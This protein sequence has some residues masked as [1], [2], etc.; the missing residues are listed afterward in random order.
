MIPNDK[1]I[2]F[3]SEEDQLVYEDVVNNRSG[4]IDTVS[5]K[6]YSP[7]LS[8]VEVFDF[9]SK[10]V[11]VK[12]FVDKIILYLQHNDRT[13]YD[14]LNEKEKTYIV[15]ILR[16]L[17]DYG[18]S[19]I[20]TK[21]REVDYVRNPVSPEEF[22][23][24]EAYIGEIG[25]N[26]YEAL[27]QEFYK[28]CN[29]EVFE[30]ILTGS[31]GWGKSYFA[32]LMMAYM[33]YKLSCLRNPHKFYGISENTPLVLMNLSVR[34]GNAKTVLFDE[35][36]ALC[37]QTHYFKEVFKRNKKINDSLVFPNKIVFMSGG[38]SEIS[39]IGQNLFSSCGDE[40]NF[41]AK[42]KN[43]RRSVDASG[44]YDQ[45]KQIYNSVI[46]RMKSRFMKQGKNAG[47]AIWISSK[48]YPGDFLE[49]RVD[50]VRKNKEKNVYII[51]KNQWEVKPQ[52]TFG[53][54]RFYV[55]VGDQTRNSRIIKTPE[56]FN[57]LRVQNQI[58]GRVVEV[59]LEYLTDFQNELEG[60][61]RDVAG[62]ATY[63]LKPYF[64]DR[65]K[66]YTCSNDAGRVK[67]LTQWYTNLQEAWPFIS[68]N[69]LQNVNVNGR[70]ARKLRH[71]PDASRFVSIDLSKT[72]DRTGFCMGC[73]AGH[74]V[75]ESVDQ[76]GKLIKIYRP[77]IFI[78][79]ILKIYPDSSGEV[80]YQRITEMVEFLRSMGYPIRQISFD[81]YQSTYHSQIFKT[82]GYQV[83]YLSVDR[84]PEAYEAL[85]SAVNGERIN[86]PS[87]QD[88]ELDGD[89]VKGVQTELIE[90]EK[91][92][93]G[94]APDHPQTGSKDT[95][96][97]LAAV[98]KQ[99][100][101]QYEP[102]SAFDSKIIVS[103]SAQ[104]ELMA[105][106]NQADP[107]SFVE[108]QM[109]MKFEDDFMDDPYLTLLDKMDRQD[110]AEF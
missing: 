102:P 79:M 106:V 89:L 96:D 32:G 99:I 29:D 33:L 95:A 25:K 11:T 100:E 64:S 110:L 18:Y 88:F 82:K 105:R 109:K 90:L 75:Y 6:V 107:F 10:N 87:M 81:Q 91:G 72:T 74:K 86:I 66:I 98:V 28:A 34:S 30:V 103:K 2:E 67:V 54:E 63:S 44:T 70:I 73:M 27:R 23:L 46:R 37:D 92:E 49:L 3:S 83:E 50:Q 20:L 94:D 62:I 78:D 108:E 57:K 69:I 8:R 65:S 26:L 84:T 35:L 38:S 56:E 17:A 80:N 104:E 76:N 21:L 47:K 59:P 101:D 12:E 14:S 9:L 7:S 16:Q 61:L 43:S 39:A 5:P 58:L 41:M 93:D 85:K 55:E 13:L 4:F 42:V 15:E 60:S 77:I 31:I 40:M 19:P 51:D 45:A 97:A 53:E 68:N 22:L 71:F 48:R 52:G 1:D 24:S 36:K